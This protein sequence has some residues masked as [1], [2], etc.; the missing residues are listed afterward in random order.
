M[1]YTKTQIRLH[2][3]M[4]ILIVIQFILHEPIAEAWEIVEEG[5]TVAFSPMIAQ[6]VVFGL[7]VL[8]LV[9][10]RFSLRRKHGAPALP[11]KEPEVMKLAAHVTHWVLY[12][13]MALMPI[14][15]AMAWFGGV[16]AAAEAHEFMRGILL[17]LILL[18]IVAALYHQFVLK[19][20]LLNRMRTP[21]YSGE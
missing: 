6:H 10:W 7:L 19:T 21:G 12:A 2:W 18:H 5:G 20:N 4:F 14:S 9:V 1:P 15:G 13:L 16:E 3:L 11:A 17:I 8:V